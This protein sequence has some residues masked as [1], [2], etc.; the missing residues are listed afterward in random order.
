MPTGHD[1]SRLWHAETL[2][3]CVLG[4]RANFAS[5]LSE[6]TESGVCSQLSRPVREQRCIH[7]FMCTLHATRSSA[8]ASA[9]RSRAPSP[10]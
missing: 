1:K 10:S 4:R 3:S 9:L 2:P 8:M 5:T 7:R 6:L